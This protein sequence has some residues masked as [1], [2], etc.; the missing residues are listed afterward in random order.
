MVD[1]IGMRNIHNGIL[2]IAPITNPK[3][4]PINPKV[5]FGILIVATILSICS[6]KLSNSLI[7]KIEKIRKIIAP[8]KLLTTTLF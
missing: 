7:N 1:K 6:T 8:I 5:I 4:P 3:T 2:A